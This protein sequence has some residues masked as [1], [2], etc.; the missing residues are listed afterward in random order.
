[1]D[2]ATWALYRRQCAGSLRQEKRPRVFGTDPA[3][4]RGLVGHL[5]LGMVTEAT[6]NVLEE[7]SSESAAA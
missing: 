5:V 1:M 3:H 2:V 4:A 6:L 7:P